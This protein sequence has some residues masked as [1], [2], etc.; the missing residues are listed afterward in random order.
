M[1]MSKIPKL[2][3]RKLFH[4]TISTSTIG[5]GLPVFVVLVSLGVGGC[6]KGTEPPTVQETTPAYVVMRIESAIPTGGNCAILYSLE[7]MG[8]QTA[9]NVM[10]WIKWYG[11]GGEEFLQPVDSISVSIKVEGTTS[12]NQ[13]WWEEYKVFWD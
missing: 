12:N 9:H 6:K 5:L 7:N 3:Y 11:G 10:P 1:S 13:C 2:A 4:G 8:G